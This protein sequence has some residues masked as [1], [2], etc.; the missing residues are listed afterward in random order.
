MDMIRRH[1]K[2]AQRGMGKMNFPQVFEF[3]DD[4]KRRTKWQKLRPDTF[5]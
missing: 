1:D 3:I 5:W 4:K 2:R